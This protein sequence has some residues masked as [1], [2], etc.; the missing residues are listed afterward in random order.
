M[1]P[2]LCR[3]FFWKRVCMPQPGRPGRLIAPLGSICVNLSPFR[4]VVRLT[5]APCHP[6]QSCIGTL[7][8][9]PLPTTCIRSMC[10]DSY[11]HWSSPLVGWFAQFDKVKC[12][13]SRSETAG[14]L[15]RQEPEWHNHVRSTS[16]IL[17]HRIVWLWRAFGLAHQ[18]HSWCWRAVNQW[19]IVTVSALGNYLALHYRATQPSVRPVEMGPG[20]DSNKHYVEWSFKIF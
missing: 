9:S 2:C 19:R 14:L 7:P 20:D 15:L 17:T 1:S 18:R 3:G 11:L 5:R 10:W 4:C 16:S 13:W 12:W 6:L 8:I